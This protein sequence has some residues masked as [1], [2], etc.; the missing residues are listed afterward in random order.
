MQ[1]GLL[2]G[3]RGSQQN[4]GRWHTEIV[5]NVDAKETITMIDDL[6]IIMCCNFD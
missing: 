2:S 3:L 6:K 5:T 4:G 1:P